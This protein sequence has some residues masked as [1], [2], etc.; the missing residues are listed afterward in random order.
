MLAGRNITDFEVGGESYKVKVQT[1][2]DYRHDPSQIND[3]V[4]KTRNGQII[5]L[6]AV[7]QIHE[8]TGAD[9]LPHYNRLRAA[10]LNAN[11]APGYTQGDAVEYMQQV[12]QRVLKDN[13]K[14]TWAGQTKDFIES[15]GAMGS[16]IV[17]ALMF[18]YL[19]LAAQFESFRDPLIIMLTV[20]F[21]IVGAV[22]LLKLTGGTNNIYTQIGFVTLIGLITKHG[23]MI[24][25]FANQL[26]EQGME[27][28]DA[29]IESATTRLRPILMTTG[30]MILGAIPLAFAGGAGAYSRQQ[31]GA[32][33]V[34]GMLIGTLFSLIVVPIAYSFLGKIRR[35]KSPNDPI[36]VALRDAE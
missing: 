17:L 21:S 25:E 8:V 16:T 7:V 34:G 22:L 11:L 6:S 27:F 5:P 4:V 3:L 18:I 35:P 30:A 13:A 14:Y 29:I 1:P 20:P 31:M 32:V 15:S 12:A 23:I 10:R 26:Q 9:S 28:L 19:V 33:I 24:T 36:T 2:N